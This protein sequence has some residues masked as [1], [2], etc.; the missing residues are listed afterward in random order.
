MV[1]FD[2]KS[3]IAHFVSIF[4]HVISYATDHP[5]SRVYAQCFALSVQL[6]LGLNYHVISCYILLAY[7]FP[8]VGSSIRSWHI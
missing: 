5:A 3:M 1:K 7:V 8:V 6:T 4:K 2:F